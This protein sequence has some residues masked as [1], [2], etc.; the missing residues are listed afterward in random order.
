MLFL[1]GQGGSQEPPL[2][3]D[4]HAFRMKDL[5]C[6]NVL[7]IGNMDTEVWTWRSFVSIYRKVKSQ[8][9]QQFESSFCTNVFAP[10]IKLRHKKLRK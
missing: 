5:R 1:V 2:P 9:H 7:A 4:A 10:K 8:I 6:G 3:P